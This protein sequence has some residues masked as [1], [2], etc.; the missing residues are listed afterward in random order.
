MKKSLFLLAVVACVSIL[1]SGLRG[2]DP[3][4]PYQPPCMERENVFAFTQKPSVRF[5]GKDR[6]EITFAVKGRCDVAAAIVDKEGRVVRHL[7]AG[8]LGPNA[9]E[10]FQRNSL[11]QKIYWNGKDDLDVYP[12]N[13]EALS[14]RVM[15]GLKPV[16]HKRLGGTSPKN[17]PGNVVG[18][19]VGS[20]AAY[21]VCKSGSAFGHATVRKFDREGNYICTLVP[22]PR[23]IPEARLGGMGYV[24]YEP[25][26]RVVQGPMVNESVAVNMW[27]LK[28]LDSNDVKTVQPVVAGNRLFFTNAGWV[29]ASPGSFLHYIY[30]DG[31][32]DV[33]GIK[34]LVLVKQHV[35]HQNVRIAASPDGKKLYFSA[36][37]HGVGSYGREAH[38]PSTCVYVR[39]ADGDGPAKPFVGTPGEPGTD[40]RHLHDPQVIDCD[41]EGRVYVADSKNNRIQIFS[42]EGKHLKTIKID[43]PNLICVHKKTGAIYVRHMARERG[44]SIERLVKLG[45]FADPREVFHVGGI[46]GFIALDSRSAKPRLWIGGGVR[47]RAGYQRKPVAWYTVRIFEEQEKTFRLVRDFVEDARK[48][49]EGSYVA[50]WHSIGSLGS[51]KVIGDPTREKVYYGRRVFDLATGAY[52]GSCEVPGADDIAFDKK[53][54]MHGHRNPGAGRIPCVW[55]VDLSRGSEKKGAIHYPECPY[56]YGVQVPGGLEGAVRTH[57][58][59]GA[60]SF[61]DGFGVNMRGDMIVESNIYYVPKMQDEGERVAMMGAKAR[62]ARGEWC[63][64]GLNY[65]RFLKS[66]EDAKKRGEEVYFIRRQPGIP[67]SGSTLWM[68]DSTGEE[69]KGSPAI[70]GNLMAGSLIDEDRSVYLT[71]RRPRLIDGR[72]FLAGKAG[73]FGAPNDKKNRTAF[74]GT[75][76]KA[77]FN[78][79]KA[80]LGRAVIPMDK[81]PDRPADAT[82]GTHVWM[83]GANWLYA[84][85]CPI[86]PGGCSCPSSR[87]HV[88]WY[89]RSYVPEAYRHSIGVLDTSGNLI[90]HL[91][92]YANFDSAPGGKEGCRPGDTD[93]GTTTPRY[94]G[95]TDNYLAFEDW[96]ERFVVLRLT[97]NAEET[98]PIGRK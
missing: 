7:G 95:G 69:V 25:G 60:K 19:A 90:M 83:E 20:K 71:M 84:G 49:D 62:S 77:R 21:V 59:P 22:P 55:R 36:C 79:L 75:F 81:K 70:I 97:Y 14:L 93:I 23:G 51:S 72:P 63:E 64:E 24:E 28:P 48:E 89:K 87:F 9:P 76:L 74:M 34:G 86:V 91:G 40:D 44:K 85:A 5:L 33:P 41:S 13:P 47:K 39:S 80:Q 58:Q 27:Y 50:H 15:L 18:L 68:Y 92:R 10:P 66:I 17:F 3:Y 8:V 46:D 16:F 43:R 65:A 82:Q 98:V 42:P 96:G 94:I 61:Q 35:V 11:S 38:L 26:R 1:A 6:Y 12:R 52:E 88:D 57:C 54:F 78:T 45:S 37:R 53:G 73:T 4:K 31:S 2:E 32:T 67:L 56:D 30:T 29:Y